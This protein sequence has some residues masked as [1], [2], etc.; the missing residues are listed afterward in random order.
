MN[1]EN[2]TAARPRVQRSEVL[3]VK[4]LG[5][6]QAATLEHPSDEVGGIA[7]FVADGLE[8]RLGFC[9]CG[10]VPFMDWSLGA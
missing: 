2:P 3:Q 9:D 1:T 5:D 8:E 6:P 10:G 4:R 7:A